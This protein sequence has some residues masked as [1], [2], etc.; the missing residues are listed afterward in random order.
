MRAAESL[1]GTGFSSIVARRARTYLAIACLPVLVPQPQHPA[2]PLVGRWE[3][4]VARSHYGGGAEPRARESL[5]CASMGIAVRCTTRSIRPD[6]RAVVAAFTAREDGTPAPV[7]GPADVDEVRLV[8]IDASI[9]DATFRYR[10][11][12]VFAYRAVR[13]SS[14][15]SLTIISVDP[16][17][18]AA[19]HSVVVYDA[20]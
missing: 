20:H 12:A 8:R 7:D 16:A 2:N 15:Q 4:N 1:G 11:Q 17:T 3:L 13:A 9:V 6:G 10:G 14:G 5:V 19:L 18:R